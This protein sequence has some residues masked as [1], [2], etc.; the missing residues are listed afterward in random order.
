MEV[1]E[2]LVTA[3]KKRDWVVLVLLSV[4]KHISYRLCPWCAI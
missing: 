2:K 4:K 3:E 1:E